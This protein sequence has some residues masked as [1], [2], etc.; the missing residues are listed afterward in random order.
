MSMV[1]YPFLV[2]VVT[3]RHDGSGV[4]LQLVRLFHLQ[5]EPQG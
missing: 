4:T 1:A 5:D 3:Q 2:G